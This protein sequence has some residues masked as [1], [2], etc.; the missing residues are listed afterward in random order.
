MYN[1]LAEMYSILAKMYFKSGILSP[2]P[3]HFLRYVESYAHMSS[4]LTMILYYMLNSFWLSPD[5]VEV[6]LGIPVFPIFYYG[7]NPKRG[8]E[9]AN[10]LQKRIL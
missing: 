3:R 10:F 4:F 7:A 8:T 9:I 6:S 1:F 5:I 2:D